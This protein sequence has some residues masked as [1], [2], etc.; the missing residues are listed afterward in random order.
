MY[1]NM[2][3][4]ALLKKLSAYEKIIIRTKTERFGM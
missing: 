1:A 2:R 4:F 3:T